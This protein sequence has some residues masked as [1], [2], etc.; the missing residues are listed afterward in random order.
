MRFMVYL[1]RRNKREGVQG[2]KDI[3]KK[4]KLIL[5]MSQLQ[6]KFDKKILMDGN[7]QIKTQDQLAKKYKAMIEREVEK[8]EI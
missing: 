3:E 4:K 1:K 7:T 2:M 6:Y 8:S 5:R